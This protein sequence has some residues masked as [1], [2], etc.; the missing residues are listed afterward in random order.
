MTKQ[1]WKQ[2]LFTDASDIKANESVK[3]AQGIIKEDL[4]NFG[5]SQKEII[6]MAV[7]YSNKY[8]KNSNL[9]NS[10]DSELRRVSNMQD[11]YFKPYDFKQALSETKTTFNLPDWA[12]WAGIGLISILGIGLIYRFTRKS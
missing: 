4:K 2:K 1:E 7:E 9:L 11:S 5:F 12:K 8:P 3:D 10:L 6:E